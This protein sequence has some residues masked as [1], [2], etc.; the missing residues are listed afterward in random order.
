MLFYFCNEEPALFWYWKCIL[1]IMII[2]K[3]IFNIVSVIK[4]NEPNILKKYSG[5]LMA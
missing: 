1:I 2:I 3:I 5:H 4:A